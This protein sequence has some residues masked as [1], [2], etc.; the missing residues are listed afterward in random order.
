MKHM[1]QKL[2]FA[3]LYLL[4]A[5][6][7]GG[8]AIL[9]ASCDK[10]KHKTHDATLF[11]DVTEPLRAWPVADE[12]T[13]LFGLEADN[14]QRVTVTVSELNDVTYNQQKVFSLEQGGTVFTTNR[15]VRTREVETFTASVSEYL[16]SLSRD[17]AIGR[18]KSSLYIP[19]AM[20]LN[21]LA[22]S[23][24]DNRVLLIYSDLMENSSLLSFYSPQIIAQLQYEPNTVMATLKRIAPIGDLT[25]VR[26]F[27]IFQPADPAAD[28]TFRLVSGFF[29]SY[30]EQHGA[31]VSISANLNP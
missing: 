9:V 11:I 3:L 23:K 29:R 24:A 25:G 2:F 5:L 20:Q 4:I 22:E 13:G 8:F 26:V 1:L 30:L 12:I 6:V 7:I 14:M 15:F 27:I 28:D 17:T 21:R 31:T 19:L 18:P 10:P 16:D